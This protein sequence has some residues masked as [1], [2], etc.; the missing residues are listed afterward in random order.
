MFSMNIWDIGLSIVEYL[1]WSGFGKVRL[2][3]IMRNLIKE[4]GFVFVLG[5]VIF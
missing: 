5:N 2:D 3:Q 4:L 1:C